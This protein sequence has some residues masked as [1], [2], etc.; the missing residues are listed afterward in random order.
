MMNKILME[1][2]RK[3]LIATLNLDEAHEILMSS[4]LKDDL[5]LDS[6]SSLTFLMM[7]EDGIEGFEV[8]P[9]TLN[10]ADLE[11]VESI[12]AYIETRVLDVE[13]Q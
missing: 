12:L 7:L 1:K 2:I 6:M 11:T 3:A 13:Q 10:G 5:G 9:E 8:D 4:K